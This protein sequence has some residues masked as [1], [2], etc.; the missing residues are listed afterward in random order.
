MA[1][2]DLNWLH[3]VGADS[4]AYVPSAKSFVC[5]TTKNNVD[6]KNN[7]TVL[8]NKQIITIVRDL[9]KRG[10]DKNSTNGHSYEVF[11][12][13]HTYNLGY[14]PRKTLQ[15][16]Q[17]HLNN[18]T[19]NAKIKGTTSGPADIFTIMDRL[20][21][22]APYHENAPDPQDGHGLEGANTVFTDGHAEFISG[23]R[24]YDRYSQSEDD[25]SGN[26][27]PYP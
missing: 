26:G 10:A 5:P 4:V 18:S 14:F 12:F 11:G 15:S 16:V 23:R 6:P 2:D 13:W 9:E 25:S 20:E 21:P 3:G 19:A 24:W 17:K 1:D 8:F 27:L 7:Y 22:H